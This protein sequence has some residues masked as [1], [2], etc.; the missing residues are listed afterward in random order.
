M[1]ITNILS[2]TGKENLIKAEKHIMIFI[3]FT[4]A[5]LLISNVAHSQIRLQALSSLERMLG[6]TVNE[7]QS[8]GRITIYAARNEKESFQVIIWAEGQLGNVH[9]ESTELISGNG[10]TIGKE[11]VHL[12][13]EIPVLLRN[14]SPRATLAPGLYYDGLV[15]FD[16]PYTNETT[17]GGRFVPQGFN[18]W[19]GQH[20]SIW[21]DIEVPKS[22]VSGIYNGN[23]KVTANNV[24]PV[25]LE[26]EL[27]VWNFA[28]PDGPTHSNHFGDFSRL[29][30]YYGTENNQE[31]G[32]RLEMRYIGLLAE[33]RLN[34]PLP[35]HLHPSVK[36]DGTI[37]ISR[38][39]D[40]EFTDFIRKYHVTDIEI[41]PAPYRYPLDGHRAVSINYYRSWYNFL[42]EKGLEQRA[43][44]YMLDEPN[45]GSDYRKVRELAEL[46][47][48][49]APDLRRL[50]VEQPYTQNPE[51]GTLDEAI[52]IWCPLFG[53]IHEPSIEKVKKQGDEVWSY[54]ALVQKAPLYH[55]DYESV[56]NDDPP[57]WGIDF[58]LTSYRV[59]TWLNRRYG[60]TG[61][62]YWTTVQWAYDRER[63]VWD[64]PGFRG[65]YNG[66]GLLIYPGEEAGIN[67]PLP[68]IRLKVL[69]DAMEDYEYFAILE[70]NGKGKMVAEIVKEV[71]P[72]WGSWKQDP[73]IYLEMRKK[74]G[75]AISQGN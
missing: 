61:L 53:F 28:L 68:T 30:A 15:P 57:Y 69:R 73:D 26:V 56:R 5:V 47:E 40:H 3:P 32:Q 8:A 10:K 75:E 51:W 13:R 29:A 36:S 22:A 65:S 19:E 34:P 2:S 18:V 11:N 39:F 9:I 44:L 1:T 7:E 35:E 37:V 63:N 21:V 14:S 6:T 67:G 17:G 25:S 48:E 72:D 46:I 33:H 50:V 16:N 70:K 52:D 62:L 71:V 55:P 38:E 24:P 54:T 20:Q 74:M 42:A 49:A 66:E 31:H 60:I 4:I 59:S 64:N 43:Y 58:P 23:I 45:I 12:Y 41:P 27:T